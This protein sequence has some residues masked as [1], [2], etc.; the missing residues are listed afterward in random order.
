MAVF[1]KQPAPVEVGIIEDIVDWLLRFFWGPKGPR[2][3]P[4]RPLHD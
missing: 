1:E 3:E 4:R 2:K